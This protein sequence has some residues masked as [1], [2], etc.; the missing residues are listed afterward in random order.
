MGLCGTTKKLNRLRLLT[1]NNRRLSRSFFTIL[2]S[3][4][5]NFRNMLNLR[6]VSASLPAAPSALRETRTAVGAAF[7]FCPPARQASG[8][9][10][11]IAR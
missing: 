11:A 2:R 7:Q 5:S 10:F 4:Q 8:K 1:K 6:R 3:L 9:P